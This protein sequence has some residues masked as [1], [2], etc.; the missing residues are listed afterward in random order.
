[1]AF[2][3][4]FKKIIIKTKKFSGSGGLSK[5]LEDNF[6]HYYFIFIIISMRRYCETVYLFY[7]FDFFLVCVCCSL[8]VPSRCVQTSPF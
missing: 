7:Q 1:M 3:N 6:H 2:K 4:W 5:M 8:F